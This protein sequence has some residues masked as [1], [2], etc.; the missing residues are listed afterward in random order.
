MS[1]G[2]VVLQR[3]HLP[4]HRFLT[5]S[6]GLEGLV[7]QLLQG[8]PRFS[9]P[10]GSHPGAAGGKLLVLELLFQGADLHVRQLLLGRISAAAPMRPVS[11]SAAKRTFSISSTG[12]TSEHR[13]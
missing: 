6:L 4:G 5:A 13:P 2:G 10:G 7:H 11:S 8:P 3:R 9:A 1:A 12:S